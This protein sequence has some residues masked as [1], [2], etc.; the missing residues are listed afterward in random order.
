M[1]TMTPRERV[2]TALARRVPDRVPATLGFRP[3]AFPGLS[4]DEVVSTL[5]LDVRYV[6]FA[7]SRD[8]EQFTDYLR[9][10]PP[11][12]DVGS[13][14]L[15]RG[16]SEWGYRPNVV[17][18][19]PLGAAESADD[20]RRFR[21]PDVTADYR[22]R[23]LTAQ[24]AAA[25][26]AGYAVAGGP[27]RLGGELFETAYRLRGFQQFM[28]DLAGR[29]ALADYLLDQLE[30]IM[31]HNVAILAEAGVDVLTIDDDVAMPTGLIL[32]PDAWRR[33]FRPRLARIIQA[34]RA[35]NPAIHILYHS[36]GDYT[37]IVPDLIAVG[38]DVLNPLQP[39]HMDPD[40]LKREHGAQVALWGAV[41]EQGLFTHGTPA[42]IRAEVR[43]RIEAL[44]PGG[45][46]VAASA[47]DV[48]FPG[49]WERVVAFADAVRAFGT[50]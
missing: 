20:L 43:R 37:A 48:D 26:A 36:D 28:T 49:G 40:R 46:Y 47:Y 27:P 33:H 45:G 21:F 22:Y 12:V 42:D 15:L 41:G 2:L 9:S 23:D 30:A 1:A 5:G 24:V 10:L 44:A 18:V 19:N 31:R 11:D 34:A 29:P 4:A 16:Y 32:S 50:Y 3:N 17:E 13:D 8:D 7:S 39:D 6:V 25:H 35:A 38:V 14:A